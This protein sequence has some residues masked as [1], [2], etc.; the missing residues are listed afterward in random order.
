V[1]ATEGCIVLALGPE[2]VHALVE[3]VNRQT[4]FGRLDNG[5]FTPLPGMAD[6]DTAP[7]QGGAAW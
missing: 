7:N 4:V 1:N 3:C 5:Q 6:L 2:G